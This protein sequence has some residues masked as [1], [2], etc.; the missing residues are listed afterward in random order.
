MEGTINVPDPVTPVVAPV[1]EAS[2]ELVAPVVDHTEKITRIEERQAQQQE[3]YIRKIAELEDRL[4]TASSDKVAGIETRIAEL[5]GKIATQ[6][7]AI[8]ATPQSVD[9]VV[10]DV[11]PSPAPPE[12][13]RQGL[14]HR[15]KARRK[16]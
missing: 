10:P 13:V 4:R 3:E 11:V 1:H 12:R 6:N 7:A 8:K 9:L 16:K 2:N 14:S 15:R 5:E